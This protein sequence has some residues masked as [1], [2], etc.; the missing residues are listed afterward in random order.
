MPFFENR[1]NIG[2][3]WWEVDVLPA[4]EYAARLRRGRPPVVGRVEGQSLVLD[5]RT[6]SPEHDA[7]LADALI[8][9]ATCE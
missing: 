3:W 2:V 5:L 6:V 4:P 1:H 8:A 9:A 7:L